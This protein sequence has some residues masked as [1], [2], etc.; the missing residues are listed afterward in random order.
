[1]SS[2]QDFTFT[3]RLSAGISYDEE[4]Y[5]IITS[6]FSPCANLPRGGAQQLQRARKIH[7]KAGFFSV[8]NNYNKY[9]MSKPLGYSENKR[10]CLSRENFSLN[11]LDV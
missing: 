1:M 6:F 8:G 3:S 4:H 9:M 7:F 5:D 10:L 2:A 11:L